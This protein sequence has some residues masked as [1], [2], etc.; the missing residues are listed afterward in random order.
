MVVAALDAVLCLQVCHELCAL[1]VDGLD[2]V[3][4]AQGSQRSFTASMDLWVGK[5]KD[6]FGCHVVLA[7]P[8]PASGGLVGY[9]GG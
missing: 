6:W 2:Q 9:E 7:P 4:R 3:S 8:A 5:P 1:P